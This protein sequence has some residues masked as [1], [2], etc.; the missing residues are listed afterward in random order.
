MPSGLATR[1]WQLIMNRLKNTQVL[2]CLLLTLGSPLLTRAEATT[3][4]QAAEADHRCAIEHI[5]RGAPDLS[6]AHEKLTQAVDYCVNFERGAGAWYLQKKL[7]RDQSV[8]SM[9][10]E[11]ALRWFRNLS[12]RY[13]KRAMHLCQQ[14]Q[15]NENQCL[16][17]LKL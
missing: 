5:Y 14:A 13:L 17:L 2:S 7:Q 10:N 3:A 12:I 1:G 15:A 9:E 4:K 8:P 16:K 11:E 6:A